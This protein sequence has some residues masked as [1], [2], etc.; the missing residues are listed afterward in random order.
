MG[1]ARFH[2]R[3]FRCVGRTGPSSHRRG[4]TLV[5]S[6]L[7]LAVLGLLLGI[8]LPVL[9]GS[10]QAAHSF[11]CQMSLRNTAFDLQMF[12]DPRLVDG[13]EHDPCDRRGH[14]GL[15]TFQESQY[16]IDEFWAYGGDRSR[17]TLTN[18]AD[19]PLRC[20]SVRGDLEL[21]RD[22]PCSAG[23]V[24][25]WQTVSYGFNSRLHRVDGPGGRSVQACLAEHVLETA[26]DVPLAWDVDGVEATRRGVTPVFSAPPM[27]G[28]G[29]YDDGHAWMP[30]V[31]HGGKVNVAFI[32]GHVLSSADP[33]AEASWR[34]AFQLDP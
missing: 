9:S 8:L 19:V 27:G 4:V 22:A 7:V 21:R 32:G 28:D 5:E 6:L 13:L 24:A 10:L 34:W 15:E 25:S 26:G 30:A 18:A 31:R 29:Q 11:A 16:G 12:L 20:A 23:G 3:R 33:L 17:A 1:P 2:V 14:V